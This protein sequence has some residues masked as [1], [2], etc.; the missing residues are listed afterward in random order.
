MFISIPVH[1]QCH[2]LLLHWL[3]HPLLLMSLSAMPANPSNS[4]PV[5]ARSA[6]CEHPGLVVVAIVA[7]AVV[8]AVPSAV[9]FAVPFATAGVAG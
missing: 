3:A 1:S 2:P 4:V 7:A 6:H 5:A 9:G 8:A